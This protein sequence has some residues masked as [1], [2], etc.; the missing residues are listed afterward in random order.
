MSHATHSTPTT[1]GS[2]QGHTPTL[3]GQAQ[4]LPPEGQTG[5]LLKLF[6]TAGLASFDEVAEAARLAP[7]EADA[8][9]EPF[10]VIDLRTA[11]L[12]REAQEVMEDQALTAFR[13]SMTARHLIPPAKFITDGRQHR[14]DVEGPGGNNDGS[15]WLCLEGIPA[16]GIQNWKDG[17]PRSASRALPRSEALP[18]L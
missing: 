7:E 10:E 5:D 1:L 6:A 3:E 17:H 15:Y 4:G 18:G 12:A 14:C 11:T 8:D 9:D 13:A 2:A 16:G